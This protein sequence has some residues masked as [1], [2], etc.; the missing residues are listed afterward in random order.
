M[1]PFSFTDDMKQFFHASGGAG[2]VVTEKDEAT[3][4]QITITKLENAIISQ[5]FD[6]IP[7]GSKNSLI[8]N[9]INPEVT[10]RRYP[11]GETF[12]WFCCTQNHREPNY[13]FI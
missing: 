2:S 10:F 5:H 11:D 6:D 1:E 3:K 9:G 4:S 12:S 7:K 13:K 8:E